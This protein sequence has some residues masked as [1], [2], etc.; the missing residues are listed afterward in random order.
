[1]QKILQMLIR[2]VEWFCGLLFKAGATLCAFEVALPAYALP[3]SARQCVRVRGVLTSMLLLMLVSTAWTGARVQLPTFAHPVAVVRM[4]EAQAQAQF[5][6]DPFTD[7]AGT[8]LSAHTGTTGATWT[9]NTSN[10]SGT[11]SIGTNDLYCSLS[12]SAYTASGTPSTADYTVESD[13][14]FLTIVA[15]TH[16]GILA[17]WSSSVDTGYFLDYQQGTG[18]VLYRHVAGASTT[19]GTRIYT[20]AAASDTYHWKLIVV[21]TSIKGEVQATNGANTGLWL[22]SSGAFV[23]GETPCIS[24][25]D[26]AVSAA[27]FA[28]VF[29]ITPT[30]STTGPHLDNFKA[31]TYVPPPA[32]G[33]SISGPAS[34]TVSVA[35]TVFTVTPTGGNL[36]GADSVT[37]SDG[38]QGGTF[39]PASPLSFSSGTNT[40]QTFTYT[41]AV[42]A[43]ITITATSATLSLPFSPTTLSYIST[44]APITLPVTTS[45][46]FFSPYNWY[47]G[48]VGTMQA[49]NVMSSATYAQTNNPGAYVK[50]VL[51][52]TTA[53]GS[54]TLN[55]DTTMM[56]A[57][58]AS[59]CPVIAW[60]IDSKQVLTQQLVY[61]STGTYQVSLATGLSAGAHTVLIYF[62]SVD[63]SNTS[64]MGDRWTTPTSVVKITGFVVDG[65]STLTAPT[66]HSKRMYAV[67]DSRGEG[68]QNVGI[69][70]G[71]TGQDSL[72]TYVQ[73][74]ANGL[75]AE[76]GV[77]AF[78]AQGLTVA[79]FGNVPVVPSAYNYYSN[80]LSRLYTSGGA[81]GGTLFYPA[82][83]YIIDGHGVNDRS[84]LSSTI[85]STNQTMIANYRAAAPNA[86]IFELLPSLWAL[87][88]HSEDRRSDGLQVCQSL[89]EQTVFD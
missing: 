9:K 15:S 34:G 42:T 30:S 55:L 33:Y 58:T 78:A 17:R 20:T 65:N 25:T 26:S 53:A 63:L 83:D 86:I 28:G 37:L 32:T 72:L 38:G 4:V 88:S 46:V 44:A 54:L 73:F 85:Q 8:L 75:D 2:L 22:N 7:T 45:T 56:S 10:G 59:G 16:V 6:V 61:Q 67:A 49:N 29:M 62:K 57:I 31:T 3:R 69:T 18:F 43:T 66:L 51:S 79:G 40:A 71:V 23:A 60:S 64:S 27:S 84:T 87:C 74:I 36:S 80:G 70:T 68:A 5:V 89:G 41:P 50:T 19:L 14:N 11:M 12:T 76:V 24:V 35:S 13:L 52:S 48:T 81:S 77:V 82:P 39:T 47:S 21:G 1:M